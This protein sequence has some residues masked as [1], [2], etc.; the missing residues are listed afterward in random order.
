[1]TDDDI[2]LAYSV[3][4]DRIREIET[5]FH[6]FEI[7][8]AKKTFRQIKDIAQSYLAVDGTEV[9]RGNRIPLW[10]FGFLY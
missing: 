6:R 1:M 4:A 3:S 7:G 8:G 2:L 9:G 5:Q 10:L